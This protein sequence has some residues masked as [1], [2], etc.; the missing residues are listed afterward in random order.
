MDLKKHPSVSETIDWAKA[1]MAMN[2]KSLDRQTLE[3]TLN[4]LL[5]YETDL[6][7]A[8]RA[9]A[10]DEDSGRGGDAGESRRE[11]RR[12]RDTRDPDEWRN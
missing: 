7:K 6:Q 3:T 12:P 10:R 1:L 8:K 4:V 9:I 2:V 11:K 5:K